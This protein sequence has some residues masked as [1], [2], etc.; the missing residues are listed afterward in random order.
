MISLGHEVDI[1]CPFPS[2]PKGTIYD[3]FKRAWWLK[4]TDQSGL[5]IIRVFSFFSRKSSFLSRFFENIS[6]GISSSFCILILKKKPDV[7]FLNTWP[8]FATFLNIFVARIFGISVIRSIQ[9]IYP[10]SL[11]SQKR[12]NQKGFIFWTLGVIEKY[13]YKRSKVNITIS[14]KMSEVLISRFPMLDRPRV[15]PNWHT[16]HN[17]V[18]YDLKREDINSQLQ[19]EDTLFVYGG[20]ISTAS[21]IIGLVNAFSIFSMNKSD[22]K[23][24][25]AGS[26]PLLD[27]CKRIVDKLNANSRIFFHSPWEIETTL[28]LFKVGDILVL[29]TDNEQA[30]YSVPSKIISYMKASRPILAFGSSN[31]ELESCIIDSGCG[32]FYDGLTKDQLILGLEESLKSNSLDRKQMGAKGYNYMIDNFD[33]NANVIKIVN[34][35]TEFTN[36]Q[37]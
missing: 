5:N 28:P 11:S 10:E 24:V 33:K 27:D 22:V 26:G 14:K 8:V 31:S 12:L 6:F 9:D 15:I 23:L 19:K 4:F 21:N 18:K 30:K 34:L 36:E 17:Q 20:N 7:I 29:P 25:V 35:I 2:R 3:G 1:L 13:N 32:W 16:I 37:S